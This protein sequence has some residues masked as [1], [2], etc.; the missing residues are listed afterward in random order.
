M[1][2]QSSTAKLASMVL[3]GILV[4][5][6]GRSSPEPVAPR[7]DVVR[8]V[9]IYFGTM[10]YTPPLQRGPL[11]Q[12]EIIQEGT[13]EEVQA[14]T[15][16]ALQQRGLRVLVDNRSEG[17]ITARYKGP[18]QNYVEC[19]TVHLSDVELGLKS[20]PVGRDRLVHGLYDGSGAQLVE[21]RDYQLQ[22][23]VTIVFRH[24][25]AS[26]AP[27]TRIT[28]SADYAL[29]NVNRRFQFDPQQTDGL[30]QLVDAGGAVTR[31][32]SEGG[33]GI[34]GSRVRCMPSGDLEWTLLRG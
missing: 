11:Q 17:L 3:I 26:L 15:L 22:A 19:G 25:A 6:C 8:V 4:V 29:V 30:G 7:V 23:L 20:E 33:A 28:A 10:D 13:P 12:V 27:A 21:T 14:R 2:A 18:L 1:A 31:F 32:T 5:G 9:P 34:E 16:M 24:Y